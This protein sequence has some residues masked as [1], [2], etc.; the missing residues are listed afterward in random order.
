MGDSFAKYYHGDPS[1]T[2]LFS[3]V[4][5]PLSGHLAELATG[6]YSSHFVAIL[7]FA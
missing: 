3:S 7:H 1:R 6:G 2:H 5:V 4:L